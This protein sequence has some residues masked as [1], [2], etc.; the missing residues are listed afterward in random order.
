MPITTEQKFPL[1]TRC[2]PI[3]HIKEVLHCFRLDLLLLLLVLLVLLLVLLLC[4]TEC[5][6]SDIFSMLLCGVSDCIYLYL[7]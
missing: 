4:V 7:V 2:H 6:T 1:W 3:L 5:L